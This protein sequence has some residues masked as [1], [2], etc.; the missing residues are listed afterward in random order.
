MTETPALTPAEQPQM[1]TAEAVAKMLDEHAARMRADF[2][3]QLESI[4]AATPVNSASDLAA[5]GPVFDKLGMQIAEL[6]D[7]NAQVQVKRL[8]PA[9]KQARDAA[10]EKMGELLTKLQSQPSSEWPIYMLVAKTQLNGKDGPRIVDPIVAIGKNEW[11]Q[12]RVRHAG[13][14]NLAMRPANAAAKAVYREYIRYL[15]GSEAANKIAPAPAAWMTFEGTHVIMGNGTTSAR[16]HGREFVAD[17]IEIDG[18]DVAA[19][20]ARNASE[21]TEEMMIPNDPRRKE[22]HVLGTLAD[23]ARVGSTSARTV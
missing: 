3:K 15:G 19:A 12:V 18:E 21:L 4:A 13:I 2:A 20:R 17:P 22:I 5:L 8:A 9:E 11:E 16:A 1:M 10:F 23:P 14:P 6:T 7:Q